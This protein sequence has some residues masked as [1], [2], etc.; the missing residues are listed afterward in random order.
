MGE[1]EFGKCEICQKEVPLKRTYFRYP[2]KCECHGSNHF[3]L[4]RHCEDCIPKEPE[5]T[6]V[7]L[8]TDDLKNPVS[9]AMKIL[10]DALKEDK[11]EGSYYHSWQSNIACTIMDNSNLDHEQVN[12][13]AKKFLDL[14]IKD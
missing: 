3:I 1:I 5:Y 2:I 7:E 13:I 10:T 12:N 11:S 14:L 8:K 6:K 4:I 9:I